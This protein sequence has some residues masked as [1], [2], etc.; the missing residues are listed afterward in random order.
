MPCPRP[1]AQP[2]TF[3]PRGLGLGAE[4]QGGTASGFLSPQRGHAAVARGR[5]VVTDIVQQKT[6]VREQVSVD[7][8]QLPRLSRALPSAMQQLL[9]L[10][11]STGDIGK[12][13][14]RRQLR[15]RLGQRC[16]D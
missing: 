5:S 8:E 3:P 14:P 15:V 2:D 7:A 9:N 10:P 12:N 6:R 1:L 13:G 11:V 16:P 4:R